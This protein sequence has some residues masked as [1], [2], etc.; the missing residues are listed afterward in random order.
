MSSAINNEFNKIRQ[1]FSKVKQ[2][3]IHIS[4][5]VHEAYTDMMQKHDNLTSEVHF[6][7]SQI[8]GHS[9]T[10]HNEKDTY[11]KHQVDA[12]KTTIRDLKKEISDIHKDHSKF[13]IELEDI[14]KRKVEARELTGIQE[15][16]HTTELEVFLLK[17][18]MLEKDVELKKLK[19]M[20]KKL[21]EIVEDLSS[22]ELNVLNSSRQSHHSTHIH[23]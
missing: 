4:S 7:S 1:S 12:L 20:N 3:M 19:E 22:V 5:Q 13:S 11:S 18:R 2:D 21:F 9:K 14:K 17:E 16:M 10:L 8:K 23:H 6:L 15:K